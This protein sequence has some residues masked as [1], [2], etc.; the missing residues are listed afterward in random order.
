[1]QTQGI[2]GANQAEVI[3][4]KY[5]CFKYAMHFIESEEI[6][7]RR[8]GYSLL[9]PQFKTLP[10][11]IQ[12]YIRYIWQAETEKGKMPYSFVKCCEKIF[13]SQ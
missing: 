8:V 13:M 10:K 3:R 9:A 1:M 12:E 6:V 2:G 11:E 7:Q 5:P 4:E